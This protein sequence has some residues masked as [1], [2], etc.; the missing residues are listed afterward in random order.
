LDAG[1]GAGGGKPGS[2]AKVWRSLDVSQYANVEKAE[3]GEHDTNNE[4]GYRDGR[5]GEVRRQGVLEDQP[6]P[7]NPVRRV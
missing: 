5:S 4:K 3:R 7:E 6:P 1:V 2:N